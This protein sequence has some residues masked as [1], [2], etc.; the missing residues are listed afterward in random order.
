M[1]VPKGRRASG[2]SGRQ[3][4]VAALLPVCRDG[5]VWPAGNIVCCAL[6]LGLSGSL[7]GPGMKQWNFK[8]RVL[9]CS[10]SDE[11]PLLA[12]RLSISPYVWK[13]AKA[14]FRTSR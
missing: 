2:S 6:V 9:T 4:A 14:K 7:L 5:G 13:E 3:G 10:A 1:A 11:D 8:I 12:S